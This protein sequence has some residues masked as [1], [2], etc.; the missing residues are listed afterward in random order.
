[1]FSFFED[2]RTQYSSK[3]LDVYR[4]HIQEVDILRDTVFGA[5]AKDSQEYRWCNTSTNGNR[6]LC[7]PVSPSLPGASTAHVRLPQ[8]ALSCPAR[9]ATRP[10]CVPSQLRP[11]LPPLPATFRDRTE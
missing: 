4:P 1:M 8:R 10:A 9:L 11:S 6:T 2:V 7:I 5:E 3:A